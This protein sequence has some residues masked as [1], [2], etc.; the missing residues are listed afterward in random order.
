MQL[1]EYRRQVANLDIREQKL[2]DL[3]LRDLGTGKIQGPRTGFTSLD[4][5]YL[6]TLPPFDYDPD[7]AKKSINDMILESPY[8]K[9]ESLALSFYGTKIDNVTLEKMKQMVAKSA[10]GAG[11]KRDDVVLMF[12]LNTPEME[13]ALYGFNMMGVC[14]E[15]TNP[16]GLNPTM[17][18][19]LIKESKAKAIFTIDILYGIIK[20]AI[21]DTDVS[22]V[23][24]N[25]VQDSFKPTMKAKYRTQ[26]FGLNALSKTNFFKE[27][28]ERINQTEEEKRTKFDR[29]LVGLDAYIVKEKIAAKA[30]YYMDQDK[31]ARFIS[32]DDFISTYYR[33][34]CE[35]HNPYELDRTSIIVHTGGTTG[36]IKRVAMTDYMMNSAIYQSTLLPLKLYPDDSLCQ[37][38]PPIV[39]WGLESHHVARFYNMNSHLIA[40]YDRNEFIPTV[41]KTKAGVYFT[42]PSFVKRFQEDPRV[43]GKDLS[44][45]H[46]IG[47]GGERMTPEDDKETDDILAKGGSN[48]KN[49]FGYGQNEEFGCFAVNFD[50]D[51]VE[52]TDYGCCGW[53]MPGN[54]YMIVDENLEELPYG[55]DPDGKPYIGELLVHGP[56]VMKGYVGDSE[57]ANEETIIYRDGKKFVRT[58]DQAYADANG[59]IWYCTRNKR[60]IRTQTGKIFTELIEKIVDQYDEVVECCCVAAP[61]PKTDKTVSCHVVL[62]ESYWS[63]PPEE[64]NGVMTRVVSR[65]EEDLRGYYDFYKPSTYEFR[66]ERIPLTSSMQKMDFIKLEESN[67]SEFE[68]N[69][70]KPLQKIRVK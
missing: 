65:L 47:Y 63:L 53:P 69:G 62:H 44:Y 64:L 35:I 56:T 15:W 55:L 21:K 29:A 27:N 8:Y 70:R 54:E 30:S 50:L 3:Y 49:Q 2:R 17:V 19:N 31:D 60:I 4:K 41:L 20:E 37:I 67:I 11:L 43:K 48:C 39:A 52:K 58:G 46:F 6:G 38:V 1:D 22:F 5:P 24:V 57:R 25:S 13:A 26:V 10:I 7:Y 68:Q 18:H 66:K 45:I 36:P 40:T 12:C 23:V 33:E 34:D 14:T 51:G 42:V 28:I 32:W 61:D 16:Q 9:P 59:K